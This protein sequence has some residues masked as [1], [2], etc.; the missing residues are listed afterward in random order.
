MRNPIGVFLYLRNAGKLSAVPMVFAVWALRRRD[1]VFQDL[2]VF[3]VR[4]GHH[5]R[6]ILQAILLDINRF[7]GLVAVLA[8]VLLHHSCH[9]WLTCR[10]CSLEREP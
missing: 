5:R 7:L 3:L 6:Q 8:L 1:L 4:L 2:D 10:L 9:V